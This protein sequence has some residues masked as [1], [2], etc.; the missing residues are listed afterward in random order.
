MDQD[1]K[2]R[3]QKVYQRIPDAPGGRRTTR[4]MMM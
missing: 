1:P 2:E 3:S 4:M